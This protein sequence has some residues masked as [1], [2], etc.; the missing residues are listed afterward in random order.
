M[1]PAKRYT[2]ERCDDCGSLV[3]GPLHTWDVR[4]RMTDRIVSNTDKRAA[5]RREAIALNAA[6]EQG[7]Q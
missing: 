1:K 5:A 2:V 4:D 3:N 7:A 6:H